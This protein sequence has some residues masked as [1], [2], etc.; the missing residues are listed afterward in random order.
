MGRRPIADPFVSTS[1]ST[2]PATCY[3]LP[4]HE[5]HLHRARDH[6]FVDAPRE[7]SAHCL[8]TSWAV[9]E[10]PVVHV[11][12]DEFIGLAAIEAARVLHRMIER[13]PAMLEPVRYTGA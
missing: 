11:H 13:L 8:T 5:L 6:A 7:Q 3:L 10:R 1:V 4:A 2:L 12:P 9:I